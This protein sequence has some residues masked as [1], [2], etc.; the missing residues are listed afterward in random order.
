MAKN[1]RA[2]CSK[3]L[4]TRR[5]TFLSLSMRLIGYFAKVRV[6]SSN[7]VARSSKGP[8]HRAFSFGTWGL[9]VPSGPFSAT[10]YQ[11]RV[12]PGSQ[13]ESREDSFPLVVARDQPPF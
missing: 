1:G 12:Q 9:A 2:C 4:M 6:A 3:W 13:S 5:N 11:F 8:G 10:R 7:L